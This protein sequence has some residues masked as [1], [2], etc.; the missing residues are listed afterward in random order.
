[1]TRRRKRGE[2]EEEVEIIE[3]TIIHQIRQILFCPIC[4]FKY[5]HS[6]TYYYF[7]VGNVRIIANPP[8]HSTRK[9]PL[10]ITL[11]VSVADVTFCSGKDGSWEGSQRR[12]G[13][14]P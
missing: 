2:E 5:K 9:R 1:M 12:V 13:Q 4:L 10:W 6:Q 7:H 14:K 3:S 11:S 8:N